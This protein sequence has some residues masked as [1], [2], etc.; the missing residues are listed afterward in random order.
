MGL[1][2]AQINMEQFFNFLAHQP[3]K[4][5]SLARNRAACSPDSRQLARESH[6]ISSSGTPSGVAPLPG[7]SPRGRH[8]ASLPASLRPPLRIC[9][10]PLA[11][12]L[13]SSAAH[14]FH[15]A[16]RSSELR[17]FRLRPWRL[18]RSLAARPPP[19]AAGP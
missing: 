8:R 4:G 1:V 6:L 19:N 2:V 5:V 9:A 11:G 15:S 13:A 7:S 14:P 17:G 10:P 16:L 3:N 18:G 12:S